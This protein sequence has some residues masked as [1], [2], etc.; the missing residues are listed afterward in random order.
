MKKL[1][2]IIALVIATVIATPAISAD[3]DSGIETPACLETASLNVVSGGVELTAS[4]DR[5]STYFTIYSIT[6]QKVKSVNVSQGT[7][8]HIDLPDGYYIVKCNDWSRRILIK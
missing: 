8:V 2:Q 6:G 7:S 5:P 3:N 1:L 4:T